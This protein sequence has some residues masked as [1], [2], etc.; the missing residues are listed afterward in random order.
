M[1]IASKHGTGD[2][3]LTPESTS[4]EDE[5]CEFTHEALLEAFARNLMRAFHIWRQQGFQPLAADYLAR[6]ALRAGGRRADLADNGDLVVNRAGS[7]ERLALLP[8]LAQAAWLDPT[9]G[10][11]R[12]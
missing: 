4:L 8:A 7:A 6:L 3:G 10:R 11:P 5:E 1:L 2:P 12:L 9:T